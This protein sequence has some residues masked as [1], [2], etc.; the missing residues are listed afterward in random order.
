M[1][2]SDP[3]IKRQS[4]EVPYF[5]R[6]IFG[7]VLFVF[8]ATTA[9]SLRP[10]CSE[11]YTRKGWQSLLAC[12][13]PPTNITKV[14][15]ILQFPAFSSDR[16]GD[17]VFSIYPGLLLGTAWGQYSFATGLYRDEAGI[18][19]GTITGHAVGK[20]IL[21]ATSTTLLRGFWIGGIMAWLYCSAYMQGMFP[22]LY[23]LPRPVAL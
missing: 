21:L 15:L 4:E 13:A 7:I 20:E 10:E 5:W 1:S 17:V 6:E 11:L 16:F 12:D 14:P 9:S 2:N 22:R 8:L 23:L 19:R 3:K 18:V